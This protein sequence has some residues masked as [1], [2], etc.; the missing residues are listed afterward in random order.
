[1]KI[2]DTCF[3]DIKKGSFNDN[4][5]IAVYVTNWSVLGGL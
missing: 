2:S 3:I 4:I 1:M 5:Y